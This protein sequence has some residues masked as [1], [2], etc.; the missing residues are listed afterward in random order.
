[1]PMWE[2]AARFCRANKKRTERFSGG[3][4]CDDDDAVDDDSDADDDA[5]AGDD[6]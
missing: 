4:D 3:D 1:M 2:L 5:C 6:D